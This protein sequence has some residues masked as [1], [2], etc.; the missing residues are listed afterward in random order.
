MD[1]LNLQLQQKN[2]RNLQ[3]DSAGFKKHQ[4][5][6]EDFYNRKDLSKPSSNNPKGNFDKALQKQLKQIEKLREDN[7]KIW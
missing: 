4:E 2:L 1:N 5:Y 6:F 3:L 7:N